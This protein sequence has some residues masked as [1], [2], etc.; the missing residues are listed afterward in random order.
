MRTRRWRLLVLAA[1]WLV[2]GLG[3]CTD[4]ITVWP[5]ARN[6]P[7]DDVDVPPLAGHWRL[8]DGGEGAPTLEVAHVPGERGQCRGGRVAYTDAGDVSE[9]GDQTCFINLDGNLVAELRSIGPM[10]GFYRQYLVRLDA[11]R[12]EVCTGLPIW[13][14]LFELKKQG[15]VG[16]SFDALQ[17]TVRDQEAG[18]LVVFISRPEP[19]REFLATALPEAAARCDLADDDFKWVVFERYEPDDEPAPAEK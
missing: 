5:I 17:Y 4:A 7:G 10:A 13:V 3:G 16:Y 1:W 15:P 14:G 6:P 11:D 8:V 2:L 19:L 12:I 18:D 9:I